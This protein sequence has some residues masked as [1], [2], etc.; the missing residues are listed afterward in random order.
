LTFMAYYFYDE[1]L[2]WTQIAGIV[3]IFIGTVLLHL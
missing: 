2:T 3:V 1:T